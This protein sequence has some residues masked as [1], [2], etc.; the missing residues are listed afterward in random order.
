MPLRWRKTP[1][2]GTGLSLLKPG[3]FYLDSEPKKPLV[4]ELVL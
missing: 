2:H 1:F 3:V 4:S